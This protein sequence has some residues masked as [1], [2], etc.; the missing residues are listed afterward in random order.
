MEHATAT[1]CAAANASLVAP[2][3]AAAPC[4]LLPAVG[5]HLSSTSQLNVGGGV[6]ATAGAARYNLYMMYM[7]CSLPAAA[8]YFIMY[9]VTGTN[10]GPALQSP[11]LESK[12]FN[13]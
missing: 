6:E 8:P 5:Q 13:V 4:C 11:A 2:T 3:A 9:V 1:A 12:P 7:C 10:C